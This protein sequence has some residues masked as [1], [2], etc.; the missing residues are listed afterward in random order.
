MIRPVQ[1][2]MENG[3]YVLTVEY[4]GSFEGTKQL[5]IDFDDVKSRLNQVSELLGREATKQDM[6]DVLKAIVKE[7]REKG[8]ETTLSLDPSELLNVDLEAEK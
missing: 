4:T 1:V 8:A 5:K 3:K 2:S 7:A 6:Q